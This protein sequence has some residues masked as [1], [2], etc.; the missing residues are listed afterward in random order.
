MIKKNEYK[1]LN[2]N[3]VYK[4]LKRAVNAAVDG[5]TKCGSYQIKI[6]RK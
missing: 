6:Q 3:K 5:C 2:C 4:Q 1:C